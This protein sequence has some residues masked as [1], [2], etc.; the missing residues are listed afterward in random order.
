MKTRH[1]AHPH[2]HLVGE[3]GGL[4]RL[5][6]KLDLA[7]PAVLHWRRRGI[8]YRRLHEVV[9]IARARGIEVTIKELTALKG[10]ETRGGKRAAC[11]LDGEAA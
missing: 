3:L 10:P 11:P 5:A 8:P 6:R 1:P 2:M 7:T 9:E 4:A